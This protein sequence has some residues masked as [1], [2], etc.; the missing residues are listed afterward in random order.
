MGFIDKNITLTA[1]LTQK[2]KEAIIDGQGIEISQFLLG[3]SDANYTNESELFDVVD[4]SGRDDC[5][6][7][8]SGNITLKYPVFFS[9]DITP[10]IDFKFNDTI[11][12]ENTI[13][14]EDNSSDQIKLISDFP[15]LDDLEL[16]VSLSSLTAFSP[17]EITYLGE[18]LPFTN[19]IVKFFIFQG[20]FESNVLTLSYNTIPPVPSGT[21]LNSIS[22]KV[23]IINTN[24]P[25]NKRLDDFSIVVNGGIIPQITFSTRTQNSTAGLNNGRIFI[26]NIRNGQM[27]YSFTI[28]RTETNTTIRNNVVISNIQSTEVQ[29]IPSGTY[30]VRVSDINGYVTERTVV[31]GELAAPVLPFDFTLTKIR[32]AFNIQPQNTG[33]FELTTIQNG[34]GFP[35]DLQVSST[36]GQFNQ[37]FNVTSL[38]FRVNNLSPNLYNVILRKGS[39]SSP[40]RQI[41]IG[42]QEI[43]NLLIEPIRRGFLANPRNII[44][45]RIRNVISV[46][47]RPHSLEY[48]M[49]NRLGVFT[50]FRPTIP[51]GNSREGILEIFSL[52]DTQR[53]FGFFSFLGQVKFIE[54]GTNREVI[55]TLTGGDVIIPNISN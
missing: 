34:S 47:A 30:I 28:I 27:P 6:K 53:P 7:G 46:S 23:E 32:D 49:R 13:T 3:D 2:G 14:K 18:T 17:S 39:V 37:I 50:E 19:N 51:I 16:N 12:L 52:E 29:N 42:T 9:G 11:V 22:T 55:Y 35:Y 44:G 43:Q 36:N 40:I 5:L 54:G 24:Q 31:V 41:T 25:I 10:L 1:Y 26:E 21:T 15:M 33:A 4:L 38:P 48:L 8:I 45:F 20:E